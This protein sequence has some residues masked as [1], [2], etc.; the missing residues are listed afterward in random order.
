MCL[1]C[2][3]IVNSLS[4]I[5]HN[6]ISLTLEHKVFLLLVSSG[7]TST[8]TTVVDHYLFHA[9]PVIFWWEPGSGAELSCYGFH[10]TQTRRR[11]R[12][13]ASFVCAPAKRQTLLVVP[14]PPRI[15]VFFAPNGD[16][17]KPTLGSY[18]IEV[19]DGDALR[20]PRAFSFAP[21]R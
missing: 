8:D 19:T 12:N 13:V 3:L 9:G 11:P 10:L 1:V 14:I 5:A 16:H 17:A 2:Q 15:T 21:T 7:F 20:K 4:K 6:I 18:T